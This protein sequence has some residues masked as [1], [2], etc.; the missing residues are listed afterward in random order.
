MYLN[1]E[2]TLV[3]PTCHVDLEET[4]DSLYC[5]HCDAFFKK[6]HPELN[7]RYREIYKDSR[8]YWRGMEQEIK[9]FCQKEKAAYR[10]FFHHNDIKK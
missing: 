5:K 3:C 4:D 9:N 10:I 1:N 2:I 8:A 7:G 6:N